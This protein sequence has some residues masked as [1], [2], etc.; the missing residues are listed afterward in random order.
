MSKTRP[1]VRQT[2]NSE[3]VPVI[4]IASTYTYID[5]FVREENAGII[6]LTHPHARTLTRSFTR[7]LI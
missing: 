2:A 3:A 7:L 4:N 1:G 6:L 5:R